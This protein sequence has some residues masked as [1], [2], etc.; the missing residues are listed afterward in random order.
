[1]VL[2]ALPHARGQEGLRGVQGQG[3]TDDLRGS[4]QGRVRGQGGCDHRDPLAE[5]VQVL[6]SQG[7]WFEGV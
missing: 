6:L 7:Y 5:R 1:M 3:V 2:Q 4:R